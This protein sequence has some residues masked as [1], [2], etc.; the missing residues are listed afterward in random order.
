MSEF[1]ELVKSFAKSREYVR[2]FFVYGFKT[3][4]E[5]N[6]KSART[7]DNEKRRLES[8]FPEFVKEDF[9]EQGKNISLAIDGNLLDTNP[10]YR[11][12]KM[13]SFTDN[14]ISLHFLIL[15]CLQTEAALNPSFTGYT[16][17]QLADVLLEKYESL[18]D[19]QTI[20]RKCND[21]AGLGLLHKEKHGKEI[22]YVTAPDFRRVISE[23]PMLADALA[24]YQLSAPMGCIADTMMDTLQLQNN[25]FR[26]KH[27]FLVHT[28]EDEILSDLLAV[29]KEKCLVRLEMRGSKTNLS[30]I[31]QCVPLQI[32]TST[33]TGRRF[34]CIYLKRAKRFRCIRMDSIKKVSKLKPIDNYDELKEQLINNYD[35]LWGVS[36]ENTDHTHRQWVRMTLHIAE[37]DEHYIVKRLKKEGKGG[38][39]TQIDE[40][41][42]TYEKEVFDANEMLPWIRSFTGRILKLESSSKRLEYRFYDDLKR[43]YETYGIKA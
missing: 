1:K 36:F 10:L 12:W 34:L 22:R 37:P 15:D 18:F 30:S 40:N 13:K 38:T 28:L 17:E 42:F 26:I 16:A 21:Y 27:S 9:T 32:F 33:R 4:D 14:D 3:R 2:D 8:W 29:M 43:M 5:F 19:T 25:I 31:H 6:A 39:I 41:T 11:V 35:Y 23:L 24:F 20:R 7:Y